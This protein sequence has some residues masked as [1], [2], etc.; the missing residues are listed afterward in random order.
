MTP[1]RP[2]PTA[3][4]RFPRHDG[5]VGINSVAEDLYSLP[6]EEFISARDAREKEAKAIGDRHLAA[7]IH[8]LRKPSTAAWL[9]NQLVREHPDEVQPYLDLGAALREANATLDGDQ[10]RELGKRQH[11]L[12]HALMLQVSALANAAGH[13]VSQDT[14]HGLEDIL[15]AALV[16]EGAAERLHTG[17]LTETLQN[18]GFPPAETLTSGRPSPA[19][20]APKTAEDSSAERRRADQLRRAERDRLRARADAK[21]AAD[22]QERAEAVAGRAETAMRDAAS[23][24]ARLRAELDTAE[25]EK[26][27]REEE[28]R[29]SQADLD[30]A[31][32]AEQEA[33]RRLEDANAARTG[34]RSSP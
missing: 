2:A 11:Q 13:K 32:R 34:Q 26:S 29:K 23:L 9:A 3:P 6:P 5:V 16:D 24:V 28:H 27:R 8:D 33:A 20:T 31:N 7:A 19:S 18:T 12:V 22:R 4:S 17:R 21:E 30:R 25:V 10:L 15:H 14:A 1:Q